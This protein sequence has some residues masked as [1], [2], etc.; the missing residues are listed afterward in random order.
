M[1]SLTFSLLFSSYYHGLSALL[2]IIFAF[3]FS[4]STAIADPIKLYKSFEG[5]IALATAGNSALN[6]TG[7]TGNCGNGNQTTD[8]CNKTQKLQNF[9]YY[10]F[11]LC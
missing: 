2:C 1:K 9:A 3:T 6:E 11:A 5:N 8:T 7:G 10:L 4:F